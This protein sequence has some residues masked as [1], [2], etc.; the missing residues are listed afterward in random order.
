MQLPSMWTLYLGVAD[1]DAAVD[2]ARGLGA[3]IIREP[4]DSEFGRV[5]TITDPTGALLNLTEVEEYVP[6]ETEDFEPD[7][8]ADL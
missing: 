5:A 3:Q 4:F 7:L 6:D 1:I 2:T 8:F